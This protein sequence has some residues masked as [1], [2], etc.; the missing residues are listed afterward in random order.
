LANAYLNFLFS[1]E[2][3]AI[4]AKHNL[5]PRDADVLKANSAR[6]PAIKTFSVEEKLGG[7]D[8][9]KKKHFADGAL[10]DQI[11]VNR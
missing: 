3:Q 6:F 5:R 4:I 11:M 7:W 9:V 8:A 2:G 10:F 1:K